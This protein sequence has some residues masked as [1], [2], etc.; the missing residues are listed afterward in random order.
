MEEY[1]KKPLFNEWLAGVLYD[2][3]VL[4]YGR[5]SHHLNSLEKYLIYNIFSQKPLKKQ[6][7]MAIKEDLIKN[8]NLLYA[9]ETIATGRDKAIDAI[10]HEESMKGGRAVTKDFLTLMFL[11]E[12]QYF[13]AGDQ[14]FN[15]YIQY[16]VYY[17]S[18]I[19][20]MSAIYES[21]AELYKYKIEKIDNIKEL[22]FRMNGKFLSDAFKESNKAHTINHFKKKYSDT[23]IVDFIY[24]IEKGV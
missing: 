13:I 10:V 16:Y 15:F 2:Y 11:L 23:A 8:K 7:S 21:A 17:T 1:I 3:I 19:D 22:H 6:I 24:C 18:S 4:Q 5:Y 14:L 20:H 9:L 12:N